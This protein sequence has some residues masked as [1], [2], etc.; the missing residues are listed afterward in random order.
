MVCSEIAAALWVSEPT[1]ARYP[2]AIVTRETETCDRCGAPSKPNDRVCA[3]CGV[4]FASS[5]GARD[6]ELFIAASMI[7]HP[8]PK[9][10][11]IATRSFFRDDVDAEL[12]ASAVAVLARDLEGERGAR[13]DAASLAALIVAYGHARR[14]LASDGHAVIRARLADGTTIERD[15]DP[16]TA[17]KLESS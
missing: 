17:A 8:R 7:E 13:L 2:H 3:H 5:S 11:A 4:A 1:G 16:A 15:L 12:V 9:A 14:S 10:L 6:L